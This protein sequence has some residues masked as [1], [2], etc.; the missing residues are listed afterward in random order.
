VK[1]IVSPVTRK[2]SKVGSMRSQPMSPGA[3]A[4]PGGSR[5][6]P[7]TKLDSAP[8]QPAEPSERVS[9]QSQEPEP[10]FGTTR[11]TGPEN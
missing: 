2:S 11:A 9:T 7:G 8:E 10:S 1:E 4:T 6:A 3:R 5:H